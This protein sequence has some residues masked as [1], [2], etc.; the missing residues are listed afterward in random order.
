LKPLVWPSLVLLLV[1]LG[2]PAW[3]DTG[4]LLLTGGVGS[5]DGAAGGGLNTGI[6]GAALGRPDLQLRQQLV[7]LKWRRSEDPQDGYV[8]ASDARRDGL[9]AGY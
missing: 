9:V 7:G 6:T 2:A 3:A 1:S 8:A 5:I 4:R